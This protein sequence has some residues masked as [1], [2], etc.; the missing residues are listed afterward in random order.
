MSR[1]RST[2][3]DEDFD[4]QMNFVFTSHWREREMVARHTA[5]LLSIAFILPIAGVVSALADTPESISGKGATVVIEMQ[6]GGTPT[7]VAAAIEAVKK[8]GG[9]ITTDEK[10][11]GNPVVS[12]NLEKT[13]ATDADLK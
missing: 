7:D 11:P 6:A 8:L 12:V 2:R 9:K 1:G 4:L 5:F 13:P 3:N 10:L